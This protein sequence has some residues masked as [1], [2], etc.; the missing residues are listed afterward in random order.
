MLRTTDQHYVAGFQHRRDGAMT[1]PE[2][3]HANSV[4]NGMGFMLIVDMPSAHAEICLCIIWCGEDNISAN[5]GIR[6]SQNRGYRG[7]FIN[8]VRRHQGDAMCRQ[9]RLYDLYIVVQVSNHD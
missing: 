4:H 8:T 7:G 9:E 3:D 6:T 1:T 2:L 5:L